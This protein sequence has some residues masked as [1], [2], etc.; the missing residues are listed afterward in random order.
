MLCV[1]KLFIIN[2]IK[3]TLFATNKFPI[4]LSPLGDITI[5][6][7]G[8][9]QMCIRD[10]PKKIEILN[11]DGNSVSDEYDYLYEFPAVMSCHK[12]CEGGSSEER[13]ILFKEGTCFP[14]RIQSKTDRLSDYC[15]E[16]VYTAYD[17]HNNVAEIRG[18]D[19]TPI[20][21]LWGYQNRFPI[22]RI[23]NATREQVLLKMGFP[24]TATNVLDS[25]SGGVEPT[26]EMKN[27]ISSL[28]VSL[29]NARVTT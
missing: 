1:Y 4:N 11:S 24:A 20:T 29:P 25:W 10:R 8:G 27:K 23:E 26:D 17:G 7:R 9:V 6:Y 12:R 3:K 22:A 13:R 15:D 19:G 14:Q 18:K 5:F 28:R 2:D 21:F 16:V